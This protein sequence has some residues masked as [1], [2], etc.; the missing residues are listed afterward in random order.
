VDAGNIAIQQMFR[1]VTG[2]VDEATVFWL[3]NNRPFPA[4]ALADALMGL[5]TEGIRAASR[6]DPALEVEPALGALAVVAEHG[7]PT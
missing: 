6:L 3:R 4:A 1:S 7:R 5:V 2:A